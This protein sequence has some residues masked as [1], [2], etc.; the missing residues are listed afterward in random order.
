MPHL[1]TNTGGSLIWPSKDTLSCPLIPPPL[2]STQGQPHR[3]LAPHPSPRNNRPYRR[4]VYARSA[5]A[6]SA[7]PKCLRI[8]TGSPPPHPKTGSSHRCHKTRAA[9]FNVVP[10]R[11]GRGHMMP[12]GFATLHAMARHHR[13][14]R[15]VTRNETAPHKQL[16]VLLISWPCVCEPI[17]SPAPQSAP[18]TPA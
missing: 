9:D 1:N 14:Q 5:P 2:W 6:P 3:P 17:T 13:P 4:K 11:R 12:T 15:P 16:P 8:S 7:H 10:R 18:E